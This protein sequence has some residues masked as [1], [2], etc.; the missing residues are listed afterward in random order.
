MA[1]P[2]PKEEKKESKVAFVLRA[3]QAPDSEYWMSAGVAFEAN[4]GG[5]VGYSIKLNQLP[6]NWNGDLLMMRPKED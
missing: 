3:K 5:E 6:V 1:K 2:A 4:I